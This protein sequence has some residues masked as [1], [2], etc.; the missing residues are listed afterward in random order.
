MSFTSA[1]EQRLENIQED[2]S[3]SFTHDQG[4]VHLSA[5]DAQWLL[6]LARN[7]ARHEPTLTKKQVKISRAIFFIF[8]SALGVLSLTGIVWGI[9]TIIRL[10]S[11]G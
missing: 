9:M 8:L 11:A 10:I 1:I 2:V 5:A 6:L 4:Q 3:Q 7:A